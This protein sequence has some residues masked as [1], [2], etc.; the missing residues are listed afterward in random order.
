MDWYLVVIIGFSSITV[1]FIL[2]LGLQYYYRMKEMEKEL[3][4]K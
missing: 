4:E 3:E 2:L 1:I